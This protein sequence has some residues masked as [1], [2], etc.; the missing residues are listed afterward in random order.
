MIVR[1]Y[2]AEISLRHIE[3]LYYPLE[4]CVSANLIER[5]FNPHISKIAIPLL[6]SLL[7]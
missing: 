7:K 1:I 4:S 6:I 3:L 5:R 2:P